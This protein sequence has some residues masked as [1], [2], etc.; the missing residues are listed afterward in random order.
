MHLVHR[1]HSLETE[2]TCKQCGVTLHP[3]Y[4]QELCPL[5][6]ER[7]LFYE[8]KDYIRENEVNEN[9]V[10]EHFDI[11]VHK[12]RGWIREGRIQYKGEKKNAISGVACQICG[13]PISYGVTCTECYKLRQLQVVA[14]LKKADPAEMHYFLQKTQSEKGV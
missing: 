1:D 8:V 2:K 13:K 4:Q 10:A 14:K 11:S 3:A 12:V 7:N 6:I 9:D 5:C